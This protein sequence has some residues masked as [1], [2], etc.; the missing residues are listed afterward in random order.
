MTL[1]LTAVIPTFFPAFTNSQIMRAPVKVLPA[2]GGPWMGSTELSNA[3]PTRQ[4]AWTTR[5]V[6]AYGQGLPAGETRRISEQQIPGGAIIARA[7][8][9]VRHDPVRDPKN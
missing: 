5:L 6:A 2:P 7:V 3:R 4:A 1:W 9:P 8:N